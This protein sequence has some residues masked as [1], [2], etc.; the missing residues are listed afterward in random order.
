MMA[1]FDTQLNKKEG[2]KSQQGGHN[3]G[4]EPEGESVAIQRPRTWLS[5]G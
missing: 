3:E 4:E 2:D 1:A 5:L